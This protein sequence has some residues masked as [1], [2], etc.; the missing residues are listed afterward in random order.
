MIASVSI[1]VD[2]ASIDCCRDALG[3]PEESSIYI[4]WGCADGHSFG[5]CKLQKILIRSNR[6]RVQTNRDEALMATGAN[7]AS[8][9][10]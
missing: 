3:V 8:A 7:L 2:R 4:R 10:V 9:K 1:G 6:L 5:R